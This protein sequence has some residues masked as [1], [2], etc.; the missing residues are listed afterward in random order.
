MIYAVLIAVG[1]L[2]PGLYDFTQMLRAGLA[3]YF[4][5]LWNYADILYIY[6]SIGNI[7]L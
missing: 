7:I 6:G 3:D 4:G 1:I 5:D 2:Y